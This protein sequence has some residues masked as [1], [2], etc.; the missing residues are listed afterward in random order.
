MIIT[1]ISDGFGNQLFMYACGYAAS[2]RLSTK[3]ALDLTYLSTNS[4]RNYEL[5]KLNISYD[6]IFSVDNIQYPLNIAVR[7]ILHLII[8]CQ[9]KIFREKT[10]YKYDKRIT[11][12]AQNSYLFGYWQ[13]EKYFKEYREDI[14]K[15]FT[16]R[17]NLS[18]E[19]NSFI[20]KVR[21]CN[22]VAVHVRRGDY[23]KLGICLDPSYY[24]NAFTVLNEKFKDLTYFVFSDNVEYAKQMFKDM[25]GTFEYVENLSS[26]STLD[27][28]FVMKEC[29]HIIMANSSYSWWAA[30]LNNNPQ[31]VAI[32]PN[33]KQFMSDFYP[34][35]WIMINNL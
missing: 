5:D 27:D 4:L 24:K 11:N 14:L 28:F 30:W 17:Y 20:D 23:V 10:A 12:I 21:S 7:K 33:D 18:Q 31:K 19:T 2:R 3:L 32:Y 35:E 9:Y 6:K 13:T 8:R 26:N 25:D 34:K 22:S 15:M 29:K 16:P 1:K